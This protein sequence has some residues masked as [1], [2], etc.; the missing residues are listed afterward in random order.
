MTSGCAASILTTHRAIHQ[1]V[2]NHT[3]AMK[4]AINRRVNGRPRALREIAKAVVQ[5]V[6]TVYSSI[7]QSPSELMGDLTF[8]AKLVKSAKHW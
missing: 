2:M 3:I 7:A 5:M 4:L 1:A 8:G 6:R